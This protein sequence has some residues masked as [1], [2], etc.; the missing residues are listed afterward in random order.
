[1]SDPNVSTGSRE[2]GTGTETA[3]EREQIHVKWS[4]LVLVRGGDPLYVCVN[5]W[6]LRV[7]E[8]LPLRSLWC[9]N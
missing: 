4:L 9:N 8:L 2:S 7:K 3:E 5:H 1:M 6:D